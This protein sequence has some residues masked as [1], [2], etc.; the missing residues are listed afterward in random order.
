MNG[1]SLFQAVVSSI[2]FL[3]GT[4]FYVLTIITFTFYRRI[5][6][7]YVIY[8]MVFLIATGF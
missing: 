3:I 4:D 1:S 8:I 6:P 2:R 7:M 5:F